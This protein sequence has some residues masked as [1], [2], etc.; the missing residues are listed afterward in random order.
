MMPCRFS[1]FVDQF[2]LTLPSLEP[3]ETGQGS[4][5]LRVPL[6]CQCSYSLQFGEC[7]AKK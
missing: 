3:I 6:R 5:V 1:Q 4:E 7:C 2:R